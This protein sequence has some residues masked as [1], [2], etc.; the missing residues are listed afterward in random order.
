MIAFL[1]YAGWGVL[2][3]GGVVLFI[4]LAAI[5]SGSGGR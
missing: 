5:V 2:V 3:V 1:E 4:N